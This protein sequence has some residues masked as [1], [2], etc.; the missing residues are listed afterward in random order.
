MLLA[1]IG[2]IENKTRNNK[3]YL[4]GFLYGL[5]VTFGVFFGVIPVIG[6]LLYYY[7]FK[8][9]DDSLPVTF[10]LGFI[11]CVVIGIAV[12]FSICLALISKYNI[13]PV[14]VR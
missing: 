14:M 10:W 4:Y 13:T 9:L 1:I 2:A 7:A 6:Q 11:F 12:V 8:S 5:A 3:S